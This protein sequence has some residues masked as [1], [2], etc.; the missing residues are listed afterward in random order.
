MLT[1][2][3]DTATDVATAAL[4]RD[5]EV[6]GER[7]SRAVR[8]LRDVEDLLTEAGLESS[9]VDRIVVG[10]GPGS[11]TGLRMGLVTAR[12]LAISL[13][14]PVAGV[15]TLAALAAGAPG[16]VP[17]IDARRR[18][19]FTLAAGEPSCVAAAAL[20]VEPGRTY[21]G[22]GAVRYRE[23][24]VAAGG[25]VPPDDAPEHVPWA[26]HHAAVAR[27]FGAADEAEPI[28]LRAPD[29]EKA[30]KR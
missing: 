21:V 30:L 19:V 2:A 28:Y 17:V 3:F 10:T 14:V 27:D 16:A 22:D 18:E 26:R 7:A 24:I 1:L 5:G 12:T 29:A 4:V 23:E 9:D 13:Q 6:L 20:G 11:Y 15:S 25:D 8:V